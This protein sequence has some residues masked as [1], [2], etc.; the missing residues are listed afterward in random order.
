V[1]ALAGSRELGLSC[2]ELVRCR[3]AVKRQEYLELLELEQVEAAIECLQVH[4]TPLAPSADQL[5]DLA[6]LLV[7]GDARELCEMAGWQGSGSKGRNAVW[8]TVQACLPSSTVVPAAR[9]RTLLAQSLQHQMTACPRYNAA[10]QWTNLLEDCR[11]GDELV[12]RTTHRLLEH[13]ADEVWHIAFSH[14]GRFLASAS[15]DTTVIIWSLYSEPLVKH[16]LKAH[17]GGATLVLHAY[18]LNL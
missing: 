5:H 15:K 16:H 14:C 12:P 17:T 13:H 10:H 3:M 6:K 11:A 4:I 1:E 8:A 2:E 7:C 18:R 9:L